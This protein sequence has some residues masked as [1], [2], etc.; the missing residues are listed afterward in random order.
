MYRDRI[1]YVLTS[2]RSGWRDCSVR[3][4]HCGGPGGPHWILVQGWVKSSIPGVADILS[5]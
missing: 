3:V 4:C 5:E 1:V 2:R